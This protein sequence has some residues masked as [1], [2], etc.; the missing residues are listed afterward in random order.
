MINKLFAVSSIN[1][2]LFQF[3]GLP[4]YFLFIFTRRFNI[5]PRKLSFLSLT[6]IL[7]LFSDNFSQ[8]VFLFANIFIAVCIRV[9]PRDILILWYILIFS[10]IVAYF[11]KYFLNSVITTY[12]HVN[13][14]GTHSGILGLIEL[15][16]FGAFFSEPSRL[17]LVMVMVLYLTHLYKVYSNSY[18]LFA[19]PI[20]LSTV[21]ISGLILL[22]FLSVILFIDSENQKSKG[23]PLIL[24]LLIFSIILSMLYVTFTILISK[25]GT[26]SMLI[27]GEPRV[28]KINRALLPILRGEIF[29]I[30]GFFNYVSLYEVNVGNWAL[31][32]VHD[33]R[34]IGIISL[35][36]ILV[37]VYFKVRFLGMLFVLGFYSMQSENHFIFVAPLIWIL[38]HEKK[39]IS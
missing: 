9:F 26:I 34:L 29:L 15:Y 23:V 7:L 30:P 8:A 17:A 3:S 20:I 28:E 1:Y 18:L 11:D 2:N 5:S 35:G 36:T 24:R 32:L 38:L 16:R 10:C 33:Y 25:Y 13:G 27:Q 22:I 12:L 21:S 31:V 37:S 14:N 19:I 4:F 39:H 6:F